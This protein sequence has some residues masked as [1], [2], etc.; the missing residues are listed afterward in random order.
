MAETALP[1]YQKAK[2]ICE[3]VLSPTDTRLGGLYNNMA[4][5]V[6]ELGGY[7]EAEEL[8]G[9]AIKIM[10]E[11]EHGEADMAITYHEKPH[12]HMPCSRRR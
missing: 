6:M 1:L 10:S 9:R 7:R 2:E 4:V 11:Q 5:T 3:A 12:T 8:F